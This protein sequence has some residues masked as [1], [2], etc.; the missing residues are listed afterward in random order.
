MERHIRIVKIEMTRT[1]GLSFFVQK[2]TFNNAGGHSPKKQVVSPAICL[3]QWT[4]REHRVR[5]IFP[6]RINPPLRQDLPSFTAVL[7]DCVG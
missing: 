2:A 7:I 3:A 4:E 1:M 5:P 6:V